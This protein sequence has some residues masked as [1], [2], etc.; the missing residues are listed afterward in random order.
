MKDASEPCL[1]I[2]RHLSYF[3][4]SLM[5]HKQTLLLLKGVVVISPPKVRQLS[6]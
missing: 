2:A 3:M 4:F 1:H 5:Q 6:R